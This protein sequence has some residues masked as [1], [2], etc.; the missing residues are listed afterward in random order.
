[1][2]RKYKNSFEPDI[3]VA[4]VTTRR[5]FESTAMPLQILTSDTNKYIEK[6]KQ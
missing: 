6:R 5:L 4:I 3:L 1:M 2:M